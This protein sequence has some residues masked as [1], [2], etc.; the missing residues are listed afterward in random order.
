M[1]ITITRKFVIV[2]LAV[3]GLVTLLVVSGLFIISK[4]TDTTGVLSQNIIHNTY[5]VTDDEGLLNVDVPELFVNMTADE[6][7][8][9]VYDRKTLYKGGV[10]DSRYAPANVTI[11]LEKGLRAATNFVKQEHLAIV[12]DTAS[13][14]LPQTYPGYTKESEKLLD[15][16][17]K[18]A[19]EFV[20][21]YTGKDSDVRIKQRLLG[22]LIDQDRIIYFRL[23]SLSTSYEEINNQYFE[24]LLKSYE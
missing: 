9:F 15:V 19:I 10:T 5:T 12:S 4:R 21:E 18:K 16:A 3:L 7:K 13:R 24:Y 17:G 11:Y 22:V 1:T 6:P 20:F 2:S 23:Q 8:G 14:A